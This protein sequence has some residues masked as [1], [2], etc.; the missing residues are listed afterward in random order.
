MKYRRL[1]THLTVVV[2]ILIN[3][4]IIAF[5]AAPTV[6]AAGTEILVDFEG[7]LPGGWFVF[8]GGGATVTASTQTVADTDPLARPGQVGDNT[9]LE[10][11]FDVT[12]GFGGFGDSFEATAVAPASLSSLKFKTTARTQVATR[13]SALTSIFSTTLAGGSR[14]SSPSPTLP[15]PPTFSR[16]GH[17]TTD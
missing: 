9:I 16:V 7:G 12:S 5:L 13:P 14:S 4:T 8:N 2:G 3:L 11:T 17:R 1:L 15:G 6:V 10:S